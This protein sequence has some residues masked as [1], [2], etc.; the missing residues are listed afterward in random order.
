MDVL[1]AE[2][3]AWTETI[4]VLLACAAAIVG[5]AHLDATAGQ[6]ERA[7][8]DEIVAERAAARAAAR[9]DAAAEARPQAMVPVDVPPRTESLGR[10][11]ILVP[12]GPA[13][14]PVGSSVVSSGT[15]TDPRIHR[16]VGHSSG[17]FVRPAGGEP[18]AQEKPAAK[19][20]PG[21]G[22][23]PQPVAADRAEAPATMLLALMAGAGLALCGLGTV[24]LGRYRA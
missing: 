24:M 13:W 7:R 14:G 15:R 9:S 4:F 20:P 16:I 18:A 17:P 19:T 6:R 11:R 23:V 2:R 5:L 1:V 3:P 21:R 8:A 12:V 22:A 10:A